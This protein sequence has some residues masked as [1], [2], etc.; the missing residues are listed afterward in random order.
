MLGWID[1]LTDAIS[2]V[3]VEVWSSIDIITNALWFALIV[4]V[5]FKRLKS[6]IQQES[7]ENDDTD[8]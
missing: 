6:T 4:M 2:L 3:L 1:K 5:I 8:E 7:K